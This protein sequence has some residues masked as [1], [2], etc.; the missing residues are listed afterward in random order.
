MKSNENHSIYYVF[1]TSDKSSWCDFRTQDLSKTHRKIEAFHPTMSAKRHDTPP[2]FPAKQRPTTSFPANDERD[3]PP[4][5]QPETLQLSSR[6]FLKPVRLCDPP[7]MGI[8]S[9]GMLK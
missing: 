8:L 5:F 3:T 4:A 7:C 2:S 6:T 9:T 1:D